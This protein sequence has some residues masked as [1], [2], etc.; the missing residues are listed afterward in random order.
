MKILIL[1]QYFPPDMGGGATRAYNVAK[2]LSS[3]GCEVTIITAFPHYPTGNIPQKYKW[4]PFVIEDTKEFRIFR[5]IVPPFSS[6]G[7]IKRILLFFSFVISSL[8]PIFLLGKIDIIWA[9]N[10]NVISM[11][12][13]YIYKKLK[14][15][16][17]IQN[18]DDLWPEVLYD[19]GVKKASMLARFGVVIANITYNMAS[20]ITPISSS[21]SLI[22]KRK[23]HVESNRINVLQAGV[24]LTR[25]A[26][27][28]SESESSS[29]NF[30]V[31]YIGSFSPAYNFYQV[32]KAAELL[33]HKPEI[34]FIIQGG[35]ELAK[36]LE[37]MATKSS[38]NIKVVSKIV[39][40]DEVA[41]I[42]GGADILLLPLCG[43][44]AIELGISSKI[45]EYQAARKPIICCSQGAPGNYVKETKSGIVVEPGDYEAL[46]EAIMY[47]KENQNEAAKFGQSGWKYVESNLSIEII[48][49]KM[50][51]LCNKLI[52]NNT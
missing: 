2:G 40:R 20:A 37:F 36:E 35:G 8:F 16:P 23:Y 3:D 18:V 31:L 10:P 44:G 52:T 19:L 42:L 9:A 26:D 32:F 46:A 22:L 1:A 45:Y 13:S 25:F 5:T 38:A 43:F 4:K 14:R 29:D 17:L 39:N 27:I 24:D 48:G 49:Q 47:L 6:Q 30:I 15:S 51:H 21:Y 28:N 41:R 12:P 33:T 34:E 50:K 7:I 11:F